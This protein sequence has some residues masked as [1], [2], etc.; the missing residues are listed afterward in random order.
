MAI[1]AISEDDIYRTSTQYRLWSFTRESLLSLRSTTNSTAA[2]SV[3]AALESLHSNL[4]SVETGSNGTET[5]RAN[6]PVEVDCL[7]VEQEQKLVGFYCVKAMQFA[8]F[9]DL[10]T[11]VKVCCTSM[12]K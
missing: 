8:D 7:T 11:N 10:P 12:P 2:G 9:C 6:T 3:R 4:D 5:Q 1:A